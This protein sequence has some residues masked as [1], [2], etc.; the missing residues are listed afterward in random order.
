MP[1]TQQRWDT[2]RAAVAAGGERF[3]ELVAA[4]DG[5]SMATA[6]WSVADTVAHVAAIASMYTR[7]VR[8]DEPAIP[9]LQDQVLA[10]TVDT[11]ADLN[12]RVLALVDER[13]PATLVTRLRSDIDDILRTTADADP[14]TPVTWLGDAKVPVCGVLAHLVNELHIHGRDIARAARKPWP[15]PPAEA[16][17]F[18]ETFFVEALRYGIGRLL[19]NDEPPSAR[20]IAVAFR[21]RHTT[22]VTIVLRDGQVSV[23]EPGGP[24]DAWVRFDPVALNLMLFHRISRTRAALTGKVAVWGR[25]PWLLPTFLRTVR[26]P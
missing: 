13:D 17:L 12:A 24:V 4:S 5:R 20:R 15:V 16:G 26:C 14:T 21:S 9:A 23:E 8:F 1:I 25:R 6:D 3:A 18:F 10:T 11:V 7:L 2:A 19:D 22:P